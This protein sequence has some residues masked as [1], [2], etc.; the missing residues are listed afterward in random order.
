MRLTGTMRIQ[1]AVLAC[2]FRGTWWRYKSLRNIQ[3]NEIINEHLP[4]ILDQQ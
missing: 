3:D 2:V 4:F 1:K